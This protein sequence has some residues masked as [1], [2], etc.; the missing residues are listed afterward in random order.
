MDWG[1]SVRWRRGGAWDL[2]YFLTWG[3]EGAKKDEEEW[4]M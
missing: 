2:G 3:M 1:V 4:S